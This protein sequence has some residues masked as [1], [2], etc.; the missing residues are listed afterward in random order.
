M[1]N[2]SFPTTQNR[3]QPSKLNGDEIARSSGLI[4]K[5]EE[6]R[7][8]APSVIPYVFQNADQI[9]GNIY[10]SLL[11]LKSIMD[12][13]VNDPTINKDHLKSLQ[14]LIDN[15]NEQIVVEIPQIISIMEI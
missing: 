2:S 14:E 3:T 1:N 9:L 5:E 4:G 8:K 11:Q 6:E 7:G 12:L 13:A 15:I 10:V